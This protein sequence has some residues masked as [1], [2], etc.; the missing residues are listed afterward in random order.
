MIGNS[1]G[2]NSQTQTGTANVV[3]NPTVT[4]APLTPTIC[5]GNSINLTASGAT[6]YTWS[7]NTAITATT[8]AN[9]TVN[10]TV[11][12]SYTLIGE[13][14][15]CTHVAVGTVSVISLPVVNVTP[16]SAT[17]CMYNYNG[18]PN[19][20]SLT[21]TGAT[22][23]TWGPIVGLTT[24]TLNGSTIVGTSDGVTAIGSGT[25]IG[26]VGTCTNVATFTVGAIP[27]PIIAVTSGSMCAG[28][29]VSLS[30][31]GA[32]TFTWSPSASLNT[33]NG[34]VVIANPSV[35]TVYS[36]IGGSVGCNSQ[37]QT[38][39]ATVVA[40]PTV[41]ITPLTPTIC[42][43]T[44]INLTANGATNYTWMPNTAITATTGANVSVNPTVTTTYSIIGEAATCTHSAVRTVTV[45]NLPVISIALSTPN[46]C[47]NNYNGSNNAVNITASGATSFN[48]VGFTGLAPNTL[49]GANVNATAIP[50]SVIGSGTVIGTANT[51]TNVATFS[52]AILP[53]PII[54]VSS[55][56][57]CFG[58]SAVLSATGADSFTWSPATTLSSPNGSSVIATPAQTSVYSVVGTSL[59]C[60]STTQTGTVTVVANPVLVISPV[61]PTICA[62]LP[63]W[64]NSIRCKQ[65]YMVTGGS[66]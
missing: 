7:P 21:A 36:V 33:P 40:N 3:P 65:L 48:W 23:Y 41:S 47:M 35:T 17:L 54:S 45:V 16:S 44:Y 42:I 55:P 10:P 59:N 6:N 26:T 43:G 64:L 12:T 25:V 28:T 4:F 18:S 58:T 32:N 20:V 52:M 29:S 66:Y 56:S 63:N 62:G 1:V 38:G 15:T 61:T 39:I 19:T 14:A 50:P 11:T 37:T 49:S 2:C 8:G 51:C 27:N 5:F 13:Q 22:T 31:S 53:N 24:N 60:N 57:M 46:I 30:A 9:V 34:N